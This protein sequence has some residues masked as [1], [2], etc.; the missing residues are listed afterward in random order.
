MHPFDVDTGDELLAAGGARKRPSDDVWWG[1]AEK[2][3]QA[4]S[5]QRA[6]LIAVT[7]L[8]AVGLTVAL[9]AFGTA[10]GTARQA[11]NSSGGGNRGSSSDTGTSGWRQ[12]RR[13]AFSSCTS[14]DVRP[15]PIWT[16][17]RWSSGPC[18]WQTRGRPCVLFV[19]EETLA[20]WPLSAP[21]ALF[22]TASFPT[23]LPLG[24][25]LLTQPPAVPVQGIIPSNPDAWV[26]LGDFAYFDDPL[27]NCDVVPDHPECNCTADFI[28]R[29]PFQCFAGVAEH[30]RLRVQLQVTTRCNCGDLDS[31]QI[32]R[33]GTN[34]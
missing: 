31:M 32:L 14:Y 13:V 3:Q 16:Q 17:V 1:V 25:N 23:T 11:N 4:K 27:I 7:V 19:E 34:A 8:A 20:V 28:R 9:A 30:A 2:T 24:C 26:W 29:P 33:G 15:Q 6:W 12:I 21:R 10:A 22:F 18:L 5:R